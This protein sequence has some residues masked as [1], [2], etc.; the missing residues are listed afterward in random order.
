MLAVESDD[1]IDH[2]AVQIASIKDVTISSEGPSSA[3][4]DYRDGGQSKPTVAPPRANKKAK[5]KCWFI[6]SRWQKRF[7]QSEFSNP[8]GAGCE[9][10]R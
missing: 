3:S 8:G 1:R 10:K 6:T 4:R 7:L 2:F 5:M 9:T